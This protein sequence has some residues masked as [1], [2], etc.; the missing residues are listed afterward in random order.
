MADAVEGALSFMTSDRH[1]KQ[2][3]HRICGAGTPSQDSMATAAS[4]Y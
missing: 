3:D 2:E 4:D 1:S